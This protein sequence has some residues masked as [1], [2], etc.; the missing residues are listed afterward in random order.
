M[1]HHITLEG[2]IGP[3]GANNVKSI[4]AKLQEAGSDPVR[5]LMNS[6]G[7]SVWEGFSVA[8]E[9]RRHAGPV[10]IRVTGLAGSIAS[11]ILTAADRVVV[12]D[13]S[14]VMIHDPSMITLG[15]EQDHR[16]SAELLDRLAG[17][18]AMGYAR[19]MDISVDAARQLMRDESWYHGEAILTAGL[20]TDYEADGEEHIAQESAAAQVAQAFGVAASGQAYW[21]AAAL[22][23][24]NGSDLDAE[25][26]EAA[27]HLKMTVHEYRHWAQKAG[28]STFID[29]SASAKTPFHTIGGKR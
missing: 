25:D 1:L 3:D 23:R 29:R 18:L 4:R 10:E 6:P 21:R 13:Q 9:I 7:G 26:R 12:T 11:Y 20:A 15:D 27:R 24:D 5:I 14:T 19:R 22:I 16:K 17:Q 8:D 2:A 28:P